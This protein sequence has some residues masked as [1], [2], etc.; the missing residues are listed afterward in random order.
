MDKD[1]LAVVQHV[2]ALVGYRAAKLVSINTAQLLKRIGN[3]NKQSKTNEVVTI[4][5]DGSVYKHH[6]RLKA[7]LE[8]L[9]QKWAP[10]HK[11]C[12]IQIFC[13]FMIIC[14]FQTV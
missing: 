1:D 14:Y 8:V 11:V 4:A 7:W 3:D 9:I 5:I 6:P 12:R 13:V 2:A 10:H